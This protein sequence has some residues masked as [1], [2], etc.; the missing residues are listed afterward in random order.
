MNGNLRLTGDSVSF[1]DLLAIDL[2]TTIRYEVRTKRRVVRGL[3]PLVG[4]WRRA[5]S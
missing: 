3:E 1:K 2:L 5:N 4:D